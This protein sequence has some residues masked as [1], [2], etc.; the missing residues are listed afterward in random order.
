MFHNLSG[1]DS[2]LFIKN[3][4]ASQGN[5]KCI[6]NNEEKYISFTKDLVIDSYTVKPKQKSPQKIVE[7]NDVPKKTTDECEQDI[8]DDVD[9]ESIMYGYD[10]DDNVPTE[11]AKSIVAEYYDDDGVPTEPTKSVFAEYYD[12]DV[13][14]E[15]TKSVFAD[16]DDDVPTTDDE[17]IFADYDDDDSE[18]I[19]DE[20]PNK[21]NIVKQLRFIDSFSSF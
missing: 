13:P 18:D 14:T 5:I 15:P 2:H 7:K 12:E 16:D 9:W 8:D 11:P 20:E 4:G 10:D 6:P 3:L 17:S 21:E 19:D 1:Y